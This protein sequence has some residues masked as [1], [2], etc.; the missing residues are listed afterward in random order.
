MIKRAQGS[1]VVTRIEGLGAMMA[2]MGEHVVNVDLVALGAP[3]RD[4]RATVLSDGI[5]VVR[6]PDLDTTVAMVDRI[7]ADVHLFCD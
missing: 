1:G 7:A 4:W 6:H 3:R 5:I 2:T